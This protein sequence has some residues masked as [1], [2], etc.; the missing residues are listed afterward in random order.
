MVRYRSRRRR[1]WRVGTALLLVLVLTVLLVSCVAGSNSLWLLRL[2]GGDLRV[3]ETESVISLIPTDGVIATELCSA[4]VFLNV[5]SV[6]MQEFHSASQ[7]IRLYRDAILN[8]LISSNYSA[9]V[10]NATLLEA[11]RQSYPHLTVSILIPES[12]FENAAAQYLGTSSVSNR[13]G[14]LF[15]YLSKADCYAIPAQIGTR[16]IAISPI[17]IA[18]TEHTYRMTFSLDDGEGDSATYSALFLKRSEGN[19]YLRALTK[20]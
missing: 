20:I 5:G 17:E 1:K 3:Y 15:S 11:V 7:A 9:Y 8:S 12:D 6:T 2:F 16:K 18:E 19:P 4:I 10:G 14:Q 13:N